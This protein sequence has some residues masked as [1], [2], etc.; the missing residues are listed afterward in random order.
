MNTK[1]TL[2][3]DDVLI[4]RAK[5]EAKNRGKSVS[6]MVSDFIE[7][8]CKIKTVESEFPPVTSSL[9]GIIAGRKIDESAYNKYLLEK[10]R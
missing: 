1:L 5:V 10:H 7:S 3:M 2:R 8:L 9:I 4:S 6:Q